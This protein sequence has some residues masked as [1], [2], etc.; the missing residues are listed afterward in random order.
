MTT[1]RKLPLHGY[2]GYYHGPNK[3]HV[4]KVIREKYIIPKGGK[5]V[6]NPGYEKGIYEVEVIVPGRK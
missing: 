3:T 5:V 6:V 2:L 4:R 1:K